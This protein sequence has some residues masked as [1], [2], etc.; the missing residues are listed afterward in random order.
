M[1]DLISVLSAGDTWLFQRIIQKCRCAILDVAMSKVTHLGS[2]FFTIFL[3][4]FLI[5]SNFRNLRLPALQAFVALSLSQFLVQVLKRKI[6]RPR[7]YFTFKNIN[8]KRPLLDCSFPS[9]HTTAGYALAVMF[10]LDFPFLSLP[11]FSLATLVGFSR[12]YLGFHYPLDVVMGAVVGGGTAY[13][14]HHYLTLASLF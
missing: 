7:P 6:A 10:A 11:L 2:A 8:V 9:G 3:C 13:T 4:M 5:A 14:V 12:T 1:K